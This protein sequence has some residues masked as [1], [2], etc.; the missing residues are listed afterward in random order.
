MPDE[1]FKRFIKTLEN[2]VT[3][4][5]G[6]TDGQITVRLRYGS[7]TAL[8]IQ[9]LAFGL[10]LLVKQFQG[11]EGGEPQPQYVLPKVGMT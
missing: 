4:L 1:Q 2:E 11:Q 7:D 5:P 10:I 6:I 8:D 3:I 9:V